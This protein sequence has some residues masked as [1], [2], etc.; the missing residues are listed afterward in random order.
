MLHDATTT[1]TLP[2]T[3]IQK[4]VIVG[5]G[6]AGWMTAAAMSKLIDLNRVSVTLIESEQI[7]TVG[8]GEATIPHIKYFNSL[9]GLSENDFVRQTN[10]TFKLGIEFNNWGHIGE[11]YFHSFGRYGVAMN[12]M[13]FWHFWQRHR[14]QGG[15]MPIDDFNLPALAAYAGKFQRP[16]EMRNSPLSN[17]SYAFQFDASLY[18]RFM[19][20]FAEA[21]GVKRIEGRV[22]DTVLDAKSGHVERVTMESGQSVPGELFIDCSGFRGLLIEQAL[23]TGYEDWSD[24]LPVN[25]AVAQAC[26][27]V[28]DPRPFTQATAQSAGWQW[29][30]PLQ[31]RTGNGHLYCSEWMDDETALDTL[32]SGMDGPAI[33]KPNFLRFTTGVRKKAWNKNV[34][35]M[36]LAAGFLEPLESTSI[37]MIQTAIAR[38]MSNFPDKTFAPANIEYYNERTRTEYEMVRDFLVL[39]YRVTRRDDSPFWNYVRTMKIPDTLRLR[40]EQFSQTSRVYRHD[41]EIFGEDSWFAVMHGQGIVP[42]GYNPMA[43]MMSQADLDAKLGHMR[44][45]WQ[46]CVDQMPSHQGFIDQHCRAMAAAAA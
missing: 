10:A 18:A 26:G 35:S 3:Q 37:H 14:A 4:I 1:D 16:N 21:R 31:S 23:K 28:T 8:V 5:G 38:L 32:Q 22:V 19:R 25:R 20:N 43:N 33:G 15:T 9:L 41:N 39:H 40:I 34:V 27:R 45:T 13:Q 7:G 42:D 11:S 24:V 44:Q 46:A 12:G 29:R 17:Y 6:T 30:I 36:G 2:D